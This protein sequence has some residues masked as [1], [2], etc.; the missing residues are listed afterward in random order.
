AI[1]VEVDEARA[2][3]P[4]KNASGE[5]RDTPE[6]VQQQMIALHRGWLQAA[7][8]E[9]VPGVAVEISPVFAQNA[10]EVAAQVRPG[11]VVTQPR[12]FC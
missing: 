6:T 10:E 7:G 9:V 4:V 8:V 1:V 5:A 3:A 12:Y 2:F 11:M